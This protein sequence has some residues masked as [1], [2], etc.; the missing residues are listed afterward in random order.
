MVLSLASDL[1]K[2]K[3]KHTNSCFIHT[4][5]S[6]LV[7][8]NIILSTILLL[9]ICYICY[10]PWFITCHHGPVPIQIISL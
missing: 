7:S 1:S 5:A 3:N 2:T 8:E 4:E 9:I 10:N 6:P